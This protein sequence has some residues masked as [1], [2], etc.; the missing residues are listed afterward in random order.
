LKKVV[1]LGS[2]G[3]IGKSALDVIRKFPDRFKVSGL[4]AKSSINILEEQMGIL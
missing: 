4:A 2:T 1:I 3:S